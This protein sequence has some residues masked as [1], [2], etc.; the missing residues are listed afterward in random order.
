MADVTQVVYGVL[1]NVADEELVQPDE[2][3]GDQKL[4]EDIGFQSLSMARILALIEGELGVD[5]FSSLVPITS[6]RT[7]DDLCAAYEKC[8][9]GEEAAQNGQV[10]A[11]VVQSL[12]RADARRNAVRGRAGRM[13]SEVERSS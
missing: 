2:I 11:E 13:Q 9:A 3:R 7:V 5:P 1:R 8:M 10:D 4:V 6:I 12:R